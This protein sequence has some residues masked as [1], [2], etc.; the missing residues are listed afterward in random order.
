MPESLTTSLERVEQHLE[1]LTSIFFAVILV[2]AFLDW[3]ARRKRDFKDTAANLA[4][5]LGQDVLGRLV[6]AP[7]ALF[8]LSFFTPL[9]PWKVPLTWWSWPLG[10]VLAD[11]FYYWTHR[12]EHRSRLFWAHHSVH[13][14]SEGFD[15][16]TAGRIAWAEPFL[17]WYGLV[18]MVLLG[19][20]P[21][22]VLV[23]SSMLLLYQTWIHTQKIGRVGLFEGVLNTPSAHRVHHGSNPEYLDANYGAV[24]MVWDRLF[25]T[26]VEEQAPVR[27]G[28][29]T[30]VG[31][32]N[33]VRINV[34]E[35]VF[36]ARQLWARARSWRD[37]ALWVFGPP[38][39][40]PE[41][42]LS[43]TRATSWWHR[44]LPAPTG[45]PLAL[46]VKA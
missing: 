31:T 7:I 46:K 44:L 20:E 6:G 22:Q 28:L 11:F 15:F 39:W 29:T 26:Y 38:E 3:R 5:G 30:P 1:L 45:S 41:K 37:A 16:S 34:H 13:H 9:A 14:S 18:P 35:Y 32:Y 27:F 23:F 36:I 24:L 2:D 17:A 10:L 33:P 40:S 19:F 43:E 42:G 12:L 21:L 8:A 25:G 4:V